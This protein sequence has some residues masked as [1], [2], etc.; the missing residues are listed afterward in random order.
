MHLMCFA[1]ISSNSSGCIFLSYIFSNEFQKE[2]TVL[3]WLILS[4]R[5]SASADDGATLKF[6]AF[7]QALIQNYG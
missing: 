4:S 3:R 5:K 1:Q 7:Q 6:V 2:K